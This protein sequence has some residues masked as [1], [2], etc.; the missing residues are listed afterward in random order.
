MA[1][2]LVAVIIVFIVIGIPTICGTFLAA[3]KVGIKNQKSQMDEDEA[4]IMQELHQGLS[5]M[6]KRIE[7][8]E[9]IIIDKK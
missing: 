1:G 2:E 3:K 8:L 6:E 5:K 4:R 9:T 7:S